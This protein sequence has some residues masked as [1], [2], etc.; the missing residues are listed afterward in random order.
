MLK[1]VEKFMVAA[2][3]LAI[4]GIITAPAAY[5]D[6]W[7]KATRITVNQPFEIPGMVLPAGTYML[8]IVNLEAERYVVRFSNEDHTKIYATLIAIPNFRLQPTDDTAIT[9]YESEINRPRAMHAWFYPAH[10]FG[11][12][13]VYPKARAAELAAVAE[14]PVIAFKEP[15]PVSTAPELAPELAPV[16][17]LPVAELLEEPIVA[18]TP[19]GE[20]VELAVV[21]P[22]FTPT[23]EP[24]LDVDYGAPLPVLPRTATPF[25]FLALAG[26]FAAGTGFAFRLFRG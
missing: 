8:K 21:Y 20:E 22:E 3:C 4:A 15:E 14:E 1:R 18:V 26:L 10:Q 12:E 19:A 6:D 7:D 24:E 16:G 17:E 25:P 9:F 11:I 23:A 13:F 2:L 5:A